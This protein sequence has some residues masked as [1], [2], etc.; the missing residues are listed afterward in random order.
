MFPNSLRIL[1]LSKNNLTKLPSDLMKLRKLKLMDLSKNRIS[2]IPFSELRSRHIKLSANCSVSDVAPGGIIC[3]N[4]NPLCDCSM[5]KFLSETEY[6]PLSNVLVEN[7]PK[8]HYHQP[9]DSHDKCPVNC[10][11]ERLH[12]SSR[13]IFCAGKGLT[14]FPVIDIE[15]ATSIELYISNNSLTELP[16]FPQ[17]M[18]ITFIDASFNQIFSIESNNLPAPLRGLNVAHNNIRTIVIDHFD[19]H[20]SLELILLNGN[21]FDC[22]C[23]VSTKNWIGFAEKFDSIID[24]HALKCDYELSV[25]AFEKYCTTQ[26]IIQVL[27]VC[28]VLI[29][30]CGTAG[31]LFYRHQQLIK[32]LLY[33]HNCCPCLVD[34]EYVDKDLEF[35]A[36]ICYSHVDKDF[37]HK[38]IESLEEGSP[39]YK[40]CVHERD[41]VGGGDIQ[42][43]VMPSNC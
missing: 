4:D 2:T 29:F 43:Q 13:R 7:C 3:L 37:V 19:K 15:Y 5:Y 39:R 17:H 30:L 38:L 6:K 24:R 10:T 36:F 35:D 40:L 21:P 27:I 18:N 16:K 34:E 41:F 8:D 12:G 20:R 22:D 31:I 23:S 28:T 42:E 9:S 32:I 1:N 25:V 14:E 26:T 11:C 33:D